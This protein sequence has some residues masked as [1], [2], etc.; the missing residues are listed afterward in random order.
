MPIECYDTTCRNHAANL[1]IPEL[2]GPFCYEKECIK[3]STR[4][5]EGHASKACR[6]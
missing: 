6:P 3:E 4:L 5:D 2:D 1:G